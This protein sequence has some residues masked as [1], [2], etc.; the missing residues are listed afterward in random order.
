MKIDE[1]LN[2]PITDPHG[3]IIPLAR[4]DT[5]QYS[6]HEM[7]KNIP[8][9]VIQVPM[10][11]KENTYCADN[12]FLPGTTWQVDKIGPQ[13]ESFLLCNGDNY[14]AISDH[15]ADKIKVEILRD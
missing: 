10:S 1:F 5:L 13:N 6:L 11:G 2:Y 9:K 14:L 3:S 15:L 8:F 7:E 4:S 12:G